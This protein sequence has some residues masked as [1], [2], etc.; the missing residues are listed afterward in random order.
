MNKGFLE[1]MPGVEWGLAAHRPHRQVSSW[2]RKA[3]VDL[4]PWA[5]LAV[6]I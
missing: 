6:G 3:D 5:S 2:E 1:D 4:E